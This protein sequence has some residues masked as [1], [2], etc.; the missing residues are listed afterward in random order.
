MTDTVLGTEGRV[1]LQEHMICWKHC[2]THT[3]IHREKDLSTNGAQM[4]ERA[5]LSDSGDGRRSHSPRKT[6]HSSPRSIL[7]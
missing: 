2:D 6:T 7:Y 3:T 1:S 4:E 5:G